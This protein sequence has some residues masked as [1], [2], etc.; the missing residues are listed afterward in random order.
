MDTQSFDNEESKQYRGQEENSSNYGERREG[1]GSYQARPRYD[2]YQDS[3]ESQRS[4]RPRYNN[5]EQ[6]SGSQPQRAFRPRINRSV[7][8]DQP[9]RAFRPRYNSSSNYDENGS[10]PQ[11]AFRPRYNG[12]SYDENSSESQPQRAFRPRVNQDADQP[13]RAFRPRYNSEDNGGSY[14]SRPSYNNNRGGY[15]NNRQ[16]GYNNGGYNNGGY[17]RQQGGYNNGYNNGGQQ[18]A[19]RPRYNQEGSNDQYNSFEGYNGNSEEGGQQGGYNNRPA[20]RPRTNNGGGYG[21]PN[22]NRGGNRKPMGRGPQKPMKKKVA[23]KPKRDKSIIKNDFFEQEIDETMINNM[24]VEEVEIDTTSIPHTLE[25]LRLN[26]FIAMS[27]VCSRR[28]ADELIKAGKVTVNGQVITEMGVQVKKT[29]HI[30]YDGRE[31]TAERKV[32][33]LLNKPKD[34]VTTTDDPEERRTVMDLVK[35]ACEERIYPVGRLDRNTTGVLLMTNDGEL[36]EHLIHP[37][38]GI[39]KIYHAFLD[40]PVAEEDMA[41]MMKGFTL[42]DGFIMADDVRYVD[43][44]DRTQ[45][46]IQLHSGKNRIVRRMFEYFGYDVVKLDRVYFAGL[47]KLKLPRGRWRFLTEVELNK[48]RAGFLK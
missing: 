14:N 33:V 19:F 18:R 21:R 27:G 32:Y 24:P 1:E 17:G 16:G 40:R 15:S 47:T 41:A 35:D 48:L 3:D 45:V 26:R 38:Y 10:Q 36:T 25:T 9:Q 12:S 43:G 46:G 28:E 22:N 31:L 34:C 30:E 4:F 23:P 29:D 42:E 2:R 39:R 44:S 5:Y 20:F 37:R 7:D 13:Q 11:R 8:S 6:G